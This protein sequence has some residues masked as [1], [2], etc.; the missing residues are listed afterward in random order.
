M[1]AAVTAGE[2]S[3]LRFEGSALACS[4]D[5]P[6]ALAD[7]ARRRRH[8]GGEGAVP[9]KVNLAYDELYGGYDCDFVFGSTGDDLVRGG[10]DDDVVEG[11]PGDDIA[12]RRRR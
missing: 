3:G 7:A 5:E 1:P 4:D 2:T 12:P 11:G 6:H 10:Q 8:G 9:G